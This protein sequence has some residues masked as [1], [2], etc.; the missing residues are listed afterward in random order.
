MTPNYIG[1][2]M[3]RVSNIR[4]VATPIIYIKV[5]T[6]TTNRLEGVFAHLKRMI[7]GIYQKFKRE[8]SQ[9]FLNEFA[10]RWSFFA[11][12]TEDKFKRI[13]AFCT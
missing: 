13:F 5:R 8:Y 4:S 3:R 2:W 6:V 11:E 12:S 10:W 7:R 9:G 1:G